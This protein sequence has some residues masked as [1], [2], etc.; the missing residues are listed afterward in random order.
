[1]QPFATELT[2]VLAI[3][4]CES[5]MLGRLTSLA[6]IN[7]LLSL[8]SALASLDLGSR[9]ERETFYSFQESL[10][11]ITETLLHKGLLLRLTS[12]LGPG[13]T[14]LLSRDDSVAGDRTTTDT[15]NEGLYCL[16]ASLA[17]SLATLSP[18]GAASLVSVGLLDRLVIV[19]YFRNPPPCLEE[20]LE[21][22]PEA[23]GAHKEALAELQRRLLP[24]LRLLTSLITASTPSAASKYDWSTVLAATE[25]IINR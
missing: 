7:T 3:S 12:A 19:P 14:E 13:P 18:S 21:F 6:A 4:A 17:S 20:L 9:I 5:S 23:L 16:T 25:V 2:E 22:G 10:N 15:V 24:T 11:T 1:M 8:L